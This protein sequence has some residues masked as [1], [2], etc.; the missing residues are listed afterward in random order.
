M[1]VLRA[2]PCPAEAVACAGVEW[3]LTST[4]TTM[5]LTVGTRL[6]HSSEA[7]AFRDS[8]WPDPKRFER[9]GRYDVT[10]LIHN[11]GRS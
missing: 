1:R 7:V 3:P 2:M 11:A 4:N 10:D 9:I 8:F 5:A 6:G